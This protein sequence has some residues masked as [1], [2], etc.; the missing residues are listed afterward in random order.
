[1]TLYRG[2]VLEGGGAKGAWQFGVLKALS[3][4]GVQFDAVSGTSVGALN[5]AIWS[6]NRTDFGEKMW[7]EISLSSTFLRH[8]ALVPVLVIGG[9]A[10]GEPR[11]LPLAQFCQI[12]QAVYRQLL[13]IALAGRRKGFNISANF[14]P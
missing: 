10:P 8:P 4:R 11:I 13:G 1:M 7:S 6:A 2:L 14:L 3:E 12:R 5:G 9:L